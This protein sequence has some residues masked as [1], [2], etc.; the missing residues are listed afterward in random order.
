MIPEL[1]VKK[2]KR[3]ELIYS[4]CIIIFTKRFIVVNKAGES[5]V[6]FKQFPRLYEYLNNTGNC[7]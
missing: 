6:L 4:I 7:G 2:A 5:N 1:M 3:N